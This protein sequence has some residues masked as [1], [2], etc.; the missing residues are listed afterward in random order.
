MSSDVLDSRS[1]VSSASSTTTTRGRISLP[2]GLRPSTRCGSTSIYRG[3]TRLMRRSRWVAHRTTSRPTMCGCW[4]VGMRSTSPK[5][6]CVQ[7][8]LR[9]VRDDRFARRCP[10]QRP[11]LTAVQQAHGGR[12]HAVLRDTDRDHT[13]FGNASWIVPGDHFDMLRLP[14]LSPPRIPYSMPQRRPRSLRRNQNMVRLR[15]I[16]CLEVERS[17]AGSGQSTQVICHEL[18][19]LEGSEFRPV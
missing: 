10:C 9:L 11:G 14:S 17:S 16:A 18:E 5:T 12:F 19:G 4:A 13:L 6:T 8:V 3:W 2:S 1:G 7:K 15:P